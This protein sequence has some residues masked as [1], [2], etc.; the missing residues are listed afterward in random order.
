MQFSHFFPNAAELAPLPEGG[1]QRVHPALKNRRYCI[2]SMGNRYQ[3]NGELVSIS[4]DRAEN[5][6]SGVPDR[7]FGTLHFMPD[8]QSRTPKI[9]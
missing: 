3:I 9:P 2:K 5:H 1:E 4:S 6:L 7:K 8:F